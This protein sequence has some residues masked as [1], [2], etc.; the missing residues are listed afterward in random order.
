MKAEGRIG[1]SEELVKKHRSDQLGEV[2]LMNC[3]IPILSEVWLLMAQ[4][5]PTASSRRPCGLEQ[6]GSGETGTEVRLKAV[7]DAWGLL[8]PHVYLISQSLCHKE[9]VKMLSKDICFKVPFLYF[10]KNI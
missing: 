8:I 4:T 6:R 9:I 5:S 2:S 3:H 10:I 7:H 1:V